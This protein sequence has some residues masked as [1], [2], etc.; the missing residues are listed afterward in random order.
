MCVEGSFALVE[1][2]G[3]LKHQWRLI[4]NQTL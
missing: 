4:K 2:S 3:V 1:V